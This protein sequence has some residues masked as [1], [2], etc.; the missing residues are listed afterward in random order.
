MFNDSL[1]FNIYIL[2]CYILLMPIF[3][4]GW[5]IIQKPNRKQGPKAHQED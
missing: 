1:F 5:P 3:L 2:C 4:K